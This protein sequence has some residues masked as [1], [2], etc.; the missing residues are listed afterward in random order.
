[1][2]K[3]Y[4]MV[5]NLENRVNSSLRFEKKFVEIF[6]SREEIISLLKVHPLSFREIYHQRYINNIYYDCPLRSRYYQAINGD[7]NREKIRVR[8]YGDF[9]GK[10]QKLTLEFKRKH[11][12]AGSK[13]SFPLGEHS[14]SSDNIRSFNTTLSQAFLPADVHEIFTS[15]LPL[16]VNRY[17]RRYYLS[18]CQKIRLT[19]DDQLEYGVASSFSEQSSMLLDREQKIIELKYSIHDHSKII[20]F[21]ND[22][23]FQLSKSSKYV[24]AVHLTLI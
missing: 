8:W 24:N 12:Q 13:T 20:R 19:I 18:F 4:F 23:P 16:T 3:A 2:S 9:W 22:F 1:M 15:L 14:V 10:N 17:R 11:G 7:S 21:S 5:L 6:R